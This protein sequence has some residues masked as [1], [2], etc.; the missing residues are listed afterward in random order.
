MSKSNI[1]QVSFKKNETDLLEYLEKNN[2]DKNFSYYVKNLIREDMKR[3]TPGA[4]ENK[5]IEN[6]INNEE[7][8]KKR[9]IDYDF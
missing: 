3:N 9:N 6:N 2:Y 7:S 1:K 4:K 8:Y 5:V